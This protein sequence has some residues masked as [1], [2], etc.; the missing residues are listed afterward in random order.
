MDVPFWLT[1]R[2]PDSGPAGVVVIESDALVYARMRATLSGV[3]AG[4]VYPCLV[5]RHGA[6]VWTKM[7][8]WTHHWSQRSQSSEMIARSQ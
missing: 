6:L 8:G 5:P 7:L 2:V 4:L 3:D 1:Y